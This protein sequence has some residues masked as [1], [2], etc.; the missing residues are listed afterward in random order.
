MVRWQFPNCVGALDGKHVLLQAPVNSGSIYFN[1]KSAHSIVL[2]A[3]VDS[4]YSFVYIDVGSNGRVS[5]G[6]IFRKSSLSLALESN[7][8]NIPPRK[9]LPGRHAA[10]PH[11]IVGDSAF[12]LKEN[13]MKPFATSDLSE[14]KN[15]IFNYR[16]SR[17][18]RVV[19]NAFGIMSNRFRIFRRP[20][21][22]E[23]TK[24][25]S[26]VL[27]TCA[28][29]N[30]LRKSSHSSADYVPPGFVDMENADGTFTPGEWR[31][32]IPTNGLLPLSHHPYT[33]SHAAKAIRAEFAEYF[34]SEGVV[35]WQEKM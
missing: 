35:P 17:A 6:G 27:A 20:I 22:I 33:H 13:I 4:D 12:P 31:N 1:Y 10:I 2:L 25:T 9:C 18:R 8:L 15:R 29:H 5:D 3:L 11:V 23:V 32:N 28:L 30:F 19:E 7:G 16:L 21:D 24:V 14:R 34:M 26:L